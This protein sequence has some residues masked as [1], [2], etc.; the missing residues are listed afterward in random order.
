MGRYSYNT[1]DESHKHKFDEYYNFYDLIP[2]YDSCSVQYVTV[3]NIQNGCA[4]CIDRLPPKLEELYCNGS[5]IQVLPDLPDTL[6]RLWCHDNKL[7]KLPKLPDSLK[8]LRCS[9][10]KLSWLPNLP[11]SLEKLDC[12]GNYLL[13]KLP[14]L[15]D[16]L[17]KLNCKLCDLFE[18]PSIPDTLYDLKCNAN[19]NLKSIPWLPKNIKC[20]H[21]HNCSLQDLPYVPYELQIYYHNHHNTKWGS[22]NNQLYL[23]RKE[24]NSL[25]IKF[26]IHENPVVNNWYPL[27][28]NYTNYDKGRLSYKRIFYN[29]MGTFQNVMIR[30]KYVDELKHWNGYMKD[31]YDYYDHKLKTEKLFVAK[32]EKWFI[33]CKYNPEYKY[34]RDRLAKEYKELYDD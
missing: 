33:D 12:S 31:V 30:P 2:F 4:N 10:N 34:C 13:T 22:C 27:R 17:L 18:L 3:L 28:Y 23:A 11:K 16:G 20:L 8:S 26:A 9:Y 24:P 15:P 32:I 29:M 19:R 25:K 7:T 14:K 6:K 1:D 5:D 21:C